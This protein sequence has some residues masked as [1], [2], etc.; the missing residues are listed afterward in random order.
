LT[1]NK[2]IELVEIAG[3][4]AFLCFFVEPQYFVDDFNIREQH[5]ST[6]VP[7]QAQAVQHI[8][9]VLACLYASC[10]FIPSVSNEFATSEASYG[11]NHF[12]FSPYL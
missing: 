9:G 11:N 12:V 2:N 7:L 1:K 10:E 6:T 3:F 4:F 8:T 5:A